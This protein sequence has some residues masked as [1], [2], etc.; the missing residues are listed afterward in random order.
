ME[1]QNIKLNVCQSVEVNC[2]NKNCKCLRNCIKDENQAGELETKETG[3]RV[4]CDTV[5]EEHFHSDNG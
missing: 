1:P 4:K 2:I 5:P 3:C